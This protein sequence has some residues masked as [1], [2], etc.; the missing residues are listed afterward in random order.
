MPFKLPRR[1][2]ALFLFLLLS[3]G[4]AAQAAPHSVAA[5]SLASPVGQ[6]QTVDDVTGKVKSI[7]AIRE[8]NGTLFGTIDKVFKPPVPKPLCIRCPGAFKNR[9]VVGLQILWGLRK[10]GSQW[11]GGQILDPETGKIYHCT[12]TLEDGGKQLR[13]RGYI[14]FSLFGRTEHWLRV[15]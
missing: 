6:W 1:V 11:W 5:S 8:Q 4:M 10:N 12:L 2:C 14:G 3:A 9:P 7:V 15:G 13:I